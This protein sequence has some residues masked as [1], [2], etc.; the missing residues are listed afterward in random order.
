MVLYHDI[1]LLHS[2]VYIGDGRW[3]FFPTLIPKVY[4][5][6][7]Y[8]KLKERSLSSSVRRLGLLV[9]SDTIAPAAVVDP[10]PWLLSGPGSV[11]H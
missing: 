3:K 6:E 11:G 4:N 1:L 5:T 8:S 9:G 10:I 7:R 2:I